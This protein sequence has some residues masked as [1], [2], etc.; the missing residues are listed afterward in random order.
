MSTT[1]TQ[2]YQDDRP[3]MLPEDTDDLQFIGLWL[4][5]TFTD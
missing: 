5:D 3:S 1:A 4:H 2:V